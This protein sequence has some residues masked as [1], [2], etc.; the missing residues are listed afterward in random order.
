V[1]VHRDD[2]NTLGNDFRLGGGVRNLRR[3][4]LS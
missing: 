4:V 1:R 2:L 3:N